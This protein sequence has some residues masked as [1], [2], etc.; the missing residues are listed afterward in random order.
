MKETQRSETVIPRR[1][2][3]R[4]PFPPGAAKPKRH[5][6]T[7]SSPA[8]LKDELVKASKASGRSLN[9]EILH[10]LARSLREEQD[11]RTDAE[12]RIDALADQIRNLVAQCFED[13]ANDYRAPASV[14]IGS[15]SSAL[16][17]V[18]DVELAAEPKSKPKSRRSG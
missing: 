9:Q 6:L 5:T 13:L 8:D 4:P 12:V 15:S 14:V 7:I 18:G 17:L 11:E 2:R 3:G 16:P 1:P 10:R